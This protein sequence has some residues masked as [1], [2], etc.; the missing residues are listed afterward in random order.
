MLTHRLK[1]WGPD[2]LAALCGHPDRGPLD[3]TPFG[4]ETT[5]TECLEIATIL[6]AAGM[7]TDEYSQ[8][9]ARLDRL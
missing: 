9:V 1:M 6:D 7:R 4:G 2:A 3:L 8:L 5:C